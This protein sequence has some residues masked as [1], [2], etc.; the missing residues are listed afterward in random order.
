MKQNSG[1]YSNPVQAGRDVI[2]NGLSYTDQRDM[3]KDISLA[4]FKDNYLVLRDELLLLVNNR[5]EEFLESFF[6]KMIE[7]KIDI[8]QLNTVEM[9]NDLY[10]AQKLYATKG[11]NYLKE[12]LNSALIE[13]M[14]S[15][16]RLIDMVISESIKTLEKLTLQ[17]LDVLTIVFLMKYYVFGETT[18]IEDL[19]LDIGFAFNPFLEGQIKNIGDYQHLEFTGCVKYVDGYKPIWY[20]FLENSPKI[21]KQYSL[22]QTMNMTMMGGAR[23]DIFLTSKEGPFIEDINNL[24]PWFAELVKFWYESPMKNIQ[25]TSVGICIAVN[26]LNIKTS[27][28]LNIDLEGLLTKTTSSWMYNY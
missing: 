1:D 19:C 12:E 4:V 26:H 7:N 13:K 8:A 17:Q 20:T 22:G 2:F 18:T 24:I 25:L 28:R 16:N 14:K 10:Q 3:M 21:V 11:D 27:N 9:Q 15:N 23:P 6:N 5:V